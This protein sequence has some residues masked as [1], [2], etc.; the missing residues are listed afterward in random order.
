MQK[1]SLENTKEQREENTW[2]YLF[3]YLTL[4]K[5]DPDPKAEA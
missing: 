3:L 2:C 4:L 5:I 1:E